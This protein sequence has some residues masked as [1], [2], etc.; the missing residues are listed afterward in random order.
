MVQPSGIS[1][2]FSRQGFLDSSTCK[3]R[4]QVAGLMLEKRR[5]SNT[6]GFGVKKLIDK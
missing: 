4:L 1:G 3:D 5:F 2:E 6:N